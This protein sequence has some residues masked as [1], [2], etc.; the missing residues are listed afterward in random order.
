MADEN[1]T[2]DLQPSISG[3]SLVIKNEDGAGVSLSLSPSKAQQVEE[4][5]DL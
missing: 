2:L 5:F 3:S 4:V 1:V